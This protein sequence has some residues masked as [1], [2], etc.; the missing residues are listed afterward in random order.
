MAKCSGCCEEQ[1]RE[2]QRY[3]RAC[4]ARY[5]RENRRPYRDLTPE[6]RKKSNARAYANEY[7]RRG[8]LVRD[9]CTDCG[10]SASQKHH[11]DYDRPLDVIWLCRVCHLKRH[12][13]SAQAEAARQAIAIVREWRRAS[14]GN[15]GNC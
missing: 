11:E 9:P 10:A 8:K 3:C 7:Q 13:A 5:M 15:E 14:P 12:R 6:A 2:G 4:H 1:D